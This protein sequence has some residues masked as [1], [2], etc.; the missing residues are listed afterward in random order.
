MWKAKQINNPAYKGPWIHPQIDNPEYV[1][2][3]NLYLYKDIGAVGFDLWQVKSGT[4]FD[5]ILITDDVERAEQVA[6]ETWQM[7]KYAEKVMKDKLDEAEKYQENKEQKTGEAEG[8]V[9][10]FFN[11]KILHFFHFISSCKSDDKQ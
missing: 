2:D 11:W 1:E 4:I 8:K 5:N 7:T 9:L 10:K 3:T 6:K